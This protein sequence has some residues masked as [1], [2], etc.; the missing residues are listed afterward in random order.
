MIASSL[1]LALLVA[2]S[3]ASPIINQRS[4][5]LVYNYTNSHGLTFSQYNNSLPN[6]AIFAT[7]TLGLTHGGRVRWS[8]ANVIPQVAPSQALGLPTQARPGIPLAQ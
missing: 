7:G 2:V 4:D 6:V 3:G 8:H 1:Y 5:G